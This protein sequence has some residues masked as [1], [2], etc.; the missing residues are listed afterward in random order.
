MRGYGIGNMGCWEIN[1]SSWIGRN[2]EGSKG[3]GIYCAEL[4]VLARAVVGI[5]CAELAVLARAFTEDYRDLFVNLG[6]S[7][8]GQRLVN[9]S[10]SVNPY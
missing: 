6:Q 2:S 3:I 9:T 4:A 5:Y 1:T 8:G 10:I 7:I